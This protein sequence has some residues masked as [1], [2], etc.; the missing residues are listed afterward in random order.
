MIEPTPTKRFVLDA[1]R[2]CNI[3]CKFCYHLHTY[4][5]W[6]NHT[7]GTEEWTRRI[8]E[9]VERGNEWMD[10]TGG[11][12]T[13][14]PEIYKIVEY[15]VSKGLKVCIITNGIVPKEKI[16]GLESAGLSEFLVSRHGQEETHNTITNNPKAYSKQH[17]FLRSL[18]Y[19]GLTLRFNCVINKFN[20][21]NLLAIAKEVAIWHPKIVNFINMNPHTDWMDKSLETQEVIADLRI[22]RPDLTE[23]IDFLEN[24]KIGVN[25]RYF[26]YCG[27]P[28]RLWRTVCND[29]HVMF[30]PYEWDYETSPKTVDRF[31]QWG[32]ETSNCVEEKGEPCNACGLR[33]AC[34]GANKHWHRASNELHGELL[35]R[36]SHG[37]SDDALPGFYYF[38]RHNTL[39]LEG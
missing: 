10:I 39:T 13:I 38:R 15:A 33:K 18:S 29:L 37:P 17:D 27:L 26:P 3:K 20:E 2:M 22:V 1:L 34:G 30:D 23:A 9:G 16:W 19:T 4:D 5:D 11:E 32:E 14:H 35:G 7:M 31:F 6:K 21:G 36:K 24:N 28:S 8:D 12:P 25:V